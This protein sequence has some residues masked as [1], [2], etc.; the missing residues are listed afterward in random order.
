MRV[1]RCNQGSRRLQPG[2]LFFP[3]SH[4]VL[5]ESQ[6]AWGLGEESC[7]KLLEVTKEE[8]GRVHG[9]ACTRK[10]SSSSYGPLINDTDIIP[11]HAYI[12]VL[13]G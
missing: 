2:P 6:L 12:E 7:R 10:Q 11:M 5:C 4:P 9:K 3:A 1:P 13:V 8:L